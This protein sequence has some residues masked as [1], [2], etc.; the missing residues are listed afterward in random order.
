MK[1]DLIMLGQMAVD[2][3]VGIY[4]VAT[5]ISEVWY[6]IPMAVASSVLSSIYAAKEISEELYYQ[7]IKKFLR[8]V[9]ILALVIALPMKFLSGTLVTTLFG[10]GYTE[11]GK[12]LAVYIWASLFVFMG[13]ATSPWSIAEGLNHLSTYRTIGAVSNVLLNLFLIP[14]Y[15][16]FGAAIATVISYALASFLSN[17]TDSETLKIFQMQVKSILMMRY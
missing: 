8:L 11:A 16:G 17:A 6:S 10:N 3:A 1:I 5:S 15:E 13:I 9:V 4:S 2:K 14:A 7:R 12:V